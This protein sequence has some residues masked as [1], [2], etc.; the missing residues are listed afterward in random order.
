M[1]Q[2]TLSDRF[3]RRNP[4][5][6]GTLIYALASEGA[7]RSPSIGWLAAFRALSAIGDAAGTIVPRA[8][9][10]DLATGQG[11]AVT[12]SPL[13]LVLGVA[14]ILAPTVG[15]LLVGLFTDGTPR[16]MAALMLLGSIGLVTADH[17]RSRRS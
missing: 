3:G 8:V 4:V 2:G 16:G 11:A 7:T 17:L 9:V 6:G 12:M 13:M 1:T 15:G 5:I 10:R 14:P